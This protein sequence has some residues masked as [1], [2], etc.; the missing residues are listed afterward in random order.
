MDNERNKLVRINISDIEYSKS[1]LKE[2]DFQLYEKLKLS[3]Q[4]QGQLKSIT[5]CELENGKYECIEGSKIL[6]CMIELNYNEVIAINIGKVTQTQKDIIRLQLFKDFFMVDYSAV[7]VMLKEI[8]NDVQVINLCNT[9]PFDKRQVENLINL[10]KFDWDA[11]NLNK[12]N[13]GQMS[14]FGNVENSTEL[15]EEEDDELLR[16]TYPANIEGSNEFN[17]FAKQEIIE[18]I[19]I[20]QPIE[21]HIEKPIQAVI[22]K[23][24]EPF[25]EKSMS[26][27]FETVKETPSIINHQ[28]IIEKEE[29]KTSVEVSHEYAH[30]V[31]EQDGEYK[32]MPERQY[33]DIGKKYEQLHRNTFSNCRLF[34]HNL[35]QKS[36]LS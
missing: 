8:L 20:E 22:E 31:Y 24:I 26:S 30:I 10:T 17:E 5:V 18:H 32:M 16:Q 4:S 29:I 36:N 15:I 23:P 11:F 28:Q 14:L 3:I 33:F 35:N 21:L 7:G 13:E 9:I 25:V 12:Q 19:K 6:K 27:L 34:I 2:N 1:K